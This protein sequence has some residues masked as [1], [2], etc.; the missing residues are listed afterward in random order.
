MLDKELSHRWTI[1]LAWLFA[2][3]SVAA[4]AATV[5]LVYGRG[6]EADNVHGTDFMWF[7]STVGIAL[8]G[9]FPC[10]LGV[11]GMAIVSLGRNL[12]AWCLLL[13]LALSSYTPGLVLLGAV[14]FL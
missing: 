12:P 10:L 9:G 4:W 13:S 7:M 8:F 2:I 11:W 5:Y 14:V 6:I 3:L 1:T